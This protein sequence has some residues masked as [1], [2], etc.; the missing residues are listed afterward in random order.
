MPKRFS[1]N[2]KEMLRT[3]RDARDKLET[4]PGADAEL[5]SVIDDII[6]IITALKALDLDRLSELLDD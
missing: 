2:L 5:K 4:L 6:H 3:L 1:Q